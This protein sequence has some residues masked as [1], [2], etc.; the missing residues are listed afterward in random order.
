LSG[1]IT[2]TTDAPIGQVIV[3]PPPVPEPATL[4]LAGLGL[5]IVGAARRLRKKKAS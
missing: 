4:L 5:P 2:S 1:P 3:N